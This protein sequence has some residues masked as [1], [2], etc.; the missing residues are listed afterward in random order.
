MLCKVMRHFHRFVHRDANFR[1]CCTHVEIIRREIRRQRRVLEQYIARHPDFA[2]SLEPLQL[3][4]GAPEVA[5]RMQAA[6]AAVGVGPMAAVAGAMAQMAVEAA[7]AAG[8]EE[9]VVE[10][11]G[12]VVLLS[13]QPVTVALYAGD[14]PLSGKLAFRFGPQTA[15]VSICSSSGRMGHS[16][17]LGRCDLATVVAP[18]ATLADAAATL[19]CNLVREPEDI[20]GVLER[21]RSLA[22]VSG[23]LLIKADKV[24]MAGRLPELIRAGDPRFE[25]KITRDRRSGPLPSHH[26]IVTGGFVS[27]RSV[28]GNIGA[29]EP[30]NDS[31]G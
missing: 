19:A 20:P 14:N 13:P 4:A 2:S 21:I 11:G 5:R 17:S 24:G 31:F 29:F 25:E 6:S 12:D 27:F 30:R 10:N 26:D 18:D 3:L 23:L 16:L 9:A 22:D 28:T 7:M 8:A 1:I 15:P